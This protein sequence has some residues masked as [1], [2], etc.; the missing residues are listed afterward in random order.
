MAPVEGL[1]DQG[2]GR[3]QSQGQGYGARAGTLRKE[4]LF[5]SDRNSTQMGQREKTGFRPQIA[6]KS[7]RG[8][9]GS[10]PGRKWGFAQCPVTV[11]DWLLCLGLV[12]TLARSVAKMA[13]VAE[14]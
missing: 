13:P 6:G 5:P 8:E 2:L 7:L 14:G 9:W 1:G 12:L 11:S 10:R 4:G 3:P